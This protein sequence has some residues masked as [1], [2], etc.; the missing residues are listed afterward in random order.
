MVPSHHCSVFARLRLTTL[1][2]PLLA[3][4]VVASLVVGLT[5]GADARPAPIGQ[6]PVNPG[7]VYS[8]DFPDP[9]VLRIGRTYYA[10]STTSDGLN[11]PMLW[12]RDL[13]H[14]RAAPGSPSNPR[15]DA[16]PRVPRWSTGESTPD[17]RMH[18]TTWA[19][20]VVRLGPGRY[21]MSYATEVHGAKGT[22][23]CVSIATATSPFGPF[24]DRTSTPTV[25]PAR[26]AIDPQIYKAPNGRPWLLWRADHFPA[27]LITQPMNWSGTSVLA[28]GKR[29]V[30]ARV[31][32]RW[33]GSIIENPAMIRYRHR[34]Y[35]FYSANSYASPRYGIGYLICKR[36]N[37]GCRRPQNGP[38]LR[39]GGAI[40]GPGGG[41]PFLDSGGH[42][43]LAY[44]AWT[45]GAVGYP[46][47][48]KCRKAPQG[49]AQRRLRV[50][51][52][53]ATKRGTLRVMSRR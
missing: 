46:D 24:V 17:G 33:E 23:M 13:R 31:A 21:V 2:R 29:R 26:G 18:T 5:I 39:T 9:G 43:R 35:L 38:L 34:W 48:V 15:G 49:C 3:V 50:A 51:L 40:S 44:H 4:S 41:T 8:G 28:S 45:T 36:W 30:L 7:A 14:W 27:L 6:D 1:A 53:F 12:S 52:L 11:V 20:S 47:S 32:Q 16:L 22:R 25:C 10:Y 37:G 19:P 42:L